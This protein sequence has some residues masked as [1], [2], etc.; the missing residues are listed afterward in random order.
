[1]S[2]SEEPCWCQ[3]TWALQSMRMDDEEE[4]LT[5]ED[6]ARQRDV[7]NLR[8]GLDRIRLLAGIH[9]LGG[10]FMPEHMRDLANLAVDALNGKEIPPIDYEGATQRALEFHHYLFQE[11]NDE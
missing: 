8:N 7:D 3:D 9:Y 2:M 1:M 4:A 5:A 11:P 6:I 10:A